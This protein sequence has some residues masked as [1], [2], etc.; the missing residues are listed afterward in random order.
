MRNRTLFYAPKIIML[1][2][3]NANRAVEIWSVPAE[4]F[5]NAHARKIITIYPMVIIGPI[6]D[7]NLANIARHAPPAQSVRPAK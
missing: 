2:A 6:L 7:P 4:M 1:M 3:T 5:L